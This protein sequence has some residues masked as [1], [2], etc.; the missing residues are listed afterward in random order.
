MNIKNVMGGGTLADNPLVVGGQVV[1]RRH[2]A[3]IQAADVT[4]PFGGDFIPHALLNT[5]TK[6]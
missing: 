5:K 2:L 4:D 3:D 1:G 6:R